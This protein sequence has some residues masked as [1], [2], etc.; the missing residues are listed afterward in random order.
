MVTLIKIK[1]SMTIS[2]GQGLKEA[3]FCVGPNKH[4]HWIN[5]CGYLQ[6]EQN[7]SFFLSIYVCHFLHA[8]SKLVMTK[9]YSN[10]LYL[11]NGT[12]KCLYFMTILL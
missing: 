4:T 12:V 1:Y 7:Y 9:E 10:Y 3:V 6:V 8:V 11:T 5:N 2:V